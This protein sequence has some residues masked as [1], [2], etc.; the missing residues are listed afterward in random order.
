MELYNVME[1]YVFQNALRILGY[2]RKLYCNVCAWHALNAH[3]LLTYF[4]LKPTILPQQWFL[5]AVLLHLPESSNSVTD[6]SNNEV[7]YLAD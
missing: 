2:N 6:K 4:I 7:Y 3:N 1:L 5:A